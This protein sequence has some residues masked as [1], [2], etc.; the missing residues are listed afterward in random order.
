M[1]HALG[2][3]LMVAMLIAAG[4]SILYAGGEVLRSWKGE[5][6]GL[7]DFFALFGTGLL[8]V[9]TGWVV[10]EVKKLRPEEN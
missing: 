7:A 8:I 4:F 5:S 3:L 2:T 10:K 1:K 9:L 6:N